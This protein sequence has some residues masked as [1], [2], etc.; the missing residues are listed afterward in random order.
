[1][2]KSVS[3]LLAF[4]MLMSCVSVAMAGTYTPGVYTATE[5]GMMGDVVVTMT[6]DEDKIVDVQVTG[7]KETPGIV[8]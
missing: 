8:A 3:M 6:F 4:L 7:E 2:K 5:F 1:M